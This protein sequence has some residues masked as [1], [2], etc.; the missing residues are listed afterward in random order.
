MGSVGTCL[1]PSPSLQHPACLTGHPRHLWAH[2]HGWKVSWLIPAAGW[3]LTA[4][5]SEL[6]RTRV[7]ALRRRY[8]H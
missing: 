7:C 6:S 3:V 1:S 2:R 8:W 4:A 5:L